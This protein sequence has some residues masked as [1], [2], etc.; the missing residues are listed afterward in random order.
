M[1]KMR[2]VSS[3]LLFLF[4]SLIMIC[5]P[6]HA[7][8]V[9]TAIAG[10]V[11]DNTGA[12]IPGAIVTITDPA[13]GQQKKA[14]TASTGEYNVNY[15]TPGSYDVAVSANGFT[16][17]EQKGVVLQINQQAKINAVMRAGGGTQVIEVSAAP[18]MLQ[19]DDASLGV[20][21]GTESAENLP[22]NGRKFDDLA[23]LTPG[24]TVSDPDNHTSSTAGS[25]INAYGSQVTWAQTNVDGTTMV[26]NR[27]AYTNIFPSVDAIQE[28]KVLTGNAEAE[29]GGGAGTITNVQL[30]T[31]GNAVHGD[32]FEFVRNTAMDAR[33][34]FR[35]A[36]LPKQ[37]LKQNQFGATLGG[38]IIKNRTFFFLSYED[39]RSV[40]QT[41][42]LTVVLTAAQRNG[43]FSALLPGTKLRNPYVLGPGNTEV[44]YN[45]N[46]IP[47]DAVAQKIVNTYTPL[48]NTSQG[49]NNYSGVT[50]GYETLSNYIVRLDHKINDT[51]QLAVHF[52][53]AY[54]NFP[55]A[56]IDPLF[57]F[58]GTYP[59]YN[60]SLQYV[61]TFSPRMV[62]E[63]RL[64]TDLEHVQQLSTRTNTSF[65]AA[66]IGING[67]VQPNGQPWPPNEEGFPTIST[68]G[69]VGMGDGTAA[70]NLDDSRTYQ[71]VDNLTWTR[72]RH[73]LIMGADIRHVQDNATTNNT[74]WG[75][76]SFSGSETGNAAAD[77]MLGV[78]SSVITP[79]GVPLSMARQWRDFLYFQDD[80]KATP[81]LTVNLGLRYDLWVPPHNNLNTSRT[82]NFSTNP[83]SIENLP[84]PVWIITHK[85]FSPRLGF[86]YSLPHQFVVR[87]GYGISF[88]GG[89]FDNLNILQLNPPADPSFSITDTTGPTTANPTNPAPSST[90]ENPISPSLTP[91]NANVAT[92]PADDKHPDLYLQTT[93]LTISKQF[94]S[95]VIDISFVDVKMTHQDTSFGSYN[96]G[97]PELSGSAQA[98]RPFPTFGTIRRVDFGG[99]GR[100][101]GMEVHFQHRLTHGLEFT[102]AYSWSHLLDNGGGD[103]NGGGSSSQGPTPQSPNGR[104][105][106]TGSTDQR[107]YATM[108]FVY[109]TPK[110][111]G[112]N[113]AT[114]AILNGWGF[115]S[116]YQY[117][118]GTPLN[119]K[120]SQDGEDNAN[121]NERPNLVS[122]QSLQIA[123]RNNGEWF[124]TGAF[125]EAMGVYGNTPRN[126]LT[127]HNRHPLTLAIKRSFPLPW[128]QQHVDFRIEAFNALNQPQFSSPGTSQGSSSFG[129][130]S[131]TSIDNRELQ[132]AL[133]YIF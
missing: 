46:Q 69:F 109:Q 115:N 116:I 41:A 43:D 112:G 37:T 131:S 24:V 132:L 29:Y 13:T 80:W 40:E 87:G 123:G 89:Q 120:Q 93:N 100:Y 70:S 75:S 88:Y 98:D 58:T 55:T 114:R 62:N 45:N 108:A 126:A 56:A 102:T 61:H 60:G 83:P 1:R 31:G 30:K 10:I 27:H 48:P 32:V 78:P 16:S 57:T 121:G 107:N 117:I 19:S 124:N 33:N 14:V 90:I 4:L 122:G 113:V 64:G 38:P 23:V 36:P 50:S 63:L 28:F 9:D 39:L 22:L 65:T 11:T 47:V 125:A 2:G 71:M 3:V 42:A 74:P 17:Y 119:I 18:P 105:W 68:S 129:K 53:Y 96:S 72:G 35:V 67:F 77:Y 66:S 85:D 6:L 97:P 84:D 95:N 127:G 52:I 81:N 101:N 7:Q 79:E 44:F 76:I 133:K 59:M 110:L 111:S 92:L 15:L 130:I 8:T 91:A 94:W 103:I 34:Y 128:E 51:N 73:T 49:A 54:R 25:S 118:S 99:A 12:V 20:V 104:E 86:A 21:I 82:L 26:N 5:M 106:A